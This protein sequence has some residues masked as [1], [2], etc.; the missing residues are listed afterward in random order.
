MDKHVTPAKTQIHYEIYSP[1]NGLT[2]CQTDP[3]DVTSP[4]PLQFMSEQDSYV[5]NTNYNS[6]QLPIRKLPSQMM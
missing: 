3:R 6:Q 4:P 1:Y 5:T 2:K